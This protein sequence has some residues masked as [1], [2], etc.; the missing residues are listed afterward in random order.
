M[1]VGHDESSLT[2]ARTLDSLYIK[3]ILGVLKRQNP[4]SH[5]VD[6]DTKKYVR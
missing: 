6:G 2:E 1:Q 3:P 4:K 5:F